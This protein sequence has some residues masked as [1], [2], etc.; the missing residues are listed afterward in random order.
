MLATG[1]V[2]EIERLLAEGRLSQR[3]ISTLVGVSRG[4]I[5]A[6]ARGARPDYEARR[7]DESE[8]DQPRGDI[9]RCPGCGGRVYMPCRLCHVRQL[10]A[11]DDALLPKLRRHRASKASVACS[12]QSSAPRQNAR[13][14]TARPPTKCSLPKKCSP[15]RLPVPIQ[16]RAEPAA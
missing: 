5:S 15:P 2:V 10:Q 8:V 12:W 1:K 14:P 3:K 16:A 11:V 6:I 9:E 13:R 7:H 4:V